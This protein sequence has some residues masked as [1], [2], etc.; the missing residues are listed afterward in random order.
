MDWMNR[1]QVMNISCNPTP[2]QP[3]IFNADFEFS[4]VRLLKMMVRVYAKLRA[5]LKFIIGTQATYITV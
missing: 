4:V 2:H 5:Y 3:S 1:H